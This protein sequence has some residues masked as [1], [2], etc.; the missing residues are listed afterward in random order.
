M[1]LDGGVP[2]RP[3]QHRVER[4]ECLAGERGRQGVHGDKCWVI[5]KAAT[6]VAS[7]TNREHTTVAQT[8]V[9]TTLTPGAEQPC[10]TNVTQRNVAAFVFCRC[11]CFFCCVPCKCCKSFYD[12][13]KL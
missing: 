8:F 4:K 13:P 9:A 11:C 2:A 5:E 3:V 12:L 1:W 10:G 6:A 7:K